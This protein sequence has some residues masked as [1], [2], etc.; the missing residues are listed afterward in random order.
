MAVTIIAPK[1]QDISK[2]VSEDIV[3]AEVVDE[4][5]SVY[6]EHKQAKEDM[7][8]LAKSV[9]KL[10]KGIIGA[11]DEVIAAGIGFTLTGNQY[12]VQLGAQ[13]EKTAVTNNEDVIDEIGQEL[14]NKLAKVS[15][16]DLK[17]YCTP[18]QLEKITKKAFAIKRRVKVEKL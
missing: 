13:G 9:L 1:V 17:A 3:P 8:P 7:A 16:T 12:E 11:V 4:F 6:V 5:A 2:I 10:E 14:F 18:D 15:I